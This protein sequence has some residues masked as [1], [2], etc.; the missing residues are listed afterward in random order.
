MVQSIRG[1]E[2]RQQRLVDAAAVHMVKAARQHLP[3]Q[4]TYRSGRRFL[5]RHNAAPG[6]TQIVDKEAHLG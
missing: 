6:R 3:Q 1:K 5:G 4:V 2:Q